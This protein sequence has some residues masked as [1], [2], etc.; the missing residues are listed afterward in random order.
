VARRL[1]VGPVCPVVV[2]VAGTNGKGSSVA[3]LESILSAA[4]YRVGSYTS[5]HLLRY[6]ER[7][8]VAGRSVDDRSLCQAFAAVERV[9]D[10]VGLTYFEF[11]TLA[12]LYI[13]ERARLDVV[14]LEVGLGGGWMR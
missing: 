9:R 8:R 13:L 5:P 2:T 14:L 7:V 1:A 12:A 3:L 6:N 10:G 4:G 11:G